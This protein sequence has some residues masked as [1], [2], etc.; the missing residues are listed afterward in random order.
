MSEAAALVPDGA[1]VA[2]GGFA[3]YQ[4]PMAF[5]RELVR[6]RRRGLTIVGT[7]SGI[8]VDMLVGAG[9]VGRIESSYVGLEKYGLAPNFRR[10]CEAGQI[11][12]VDY[13]EVL[14]F[15]R[16][17]A[18]GENFAFW[19]C[20]YL[21]G[22]DILTYNPDIRPFNCP[23]TGRP[24]HAVPAAAPDVAV[25]HGVAADAS[26]N[27]LMAR[28]RLL[29]QE[30]DLAI[31]SS[32]DT[33]IVTV[34]K[35]VSNG[36]IR[37]HSELNMIPAYRTT[38]IVEAPLGSHPTPTLSRWLTDGEHLEQYVKAAE[39]DTQFADYLDRWVRRPADHAAYLDLLGTARMA[40]LMEIDAL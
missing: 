12:M 13:P 15:D 3:N 16:F 26:G 21:G 1:R 17:R 37:R 24:L 30:L 2:I 35:I 32:C 11:D 8:E 10:A 7:V 40:R 33:L 34:E 39:S 9:A 5:V 27:V 4:R 38:A 18:S 20:S 36:F 25:L 28:H 19:P 6:Q 23:I 29:P 14:S 22:T 31:A